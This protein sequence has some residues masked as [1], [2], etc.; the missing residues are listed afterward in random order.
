MVLVTFS[1]NG[2]YRYLGFETHVGS[3]SLIDV[4]HYRGKPAALISSWS[5]ETEGIILDSKE[6]LEHVLTN[7]PGVLYAVNFWTSH[8]PCL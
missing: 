7:P 3:L 6:H 1:G 2:E 5:G 8:G 4:G